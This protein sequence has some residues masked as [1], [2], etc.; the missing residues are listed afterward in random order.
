VTVGPLALR[1]VDGI[2]VATLTGEIDL[3]NANHIRDRIAET[4]K[5]T[6]LGVVMDLSAIDYLDSAGVRMLF[7]LAERLHAR[8]QALRLVVQTAAIVRRVLALT[9]LEAKIPFDDT[10]EASVRALTPS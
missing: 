1:E 7:D 10:V 9:K 3:A 6:D 5:P 8:R 4:V 2:L